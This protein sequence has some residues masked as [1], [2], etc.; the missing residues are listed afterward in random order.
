M[1]LVRDK[2]SWDN[3]KNKF[4]GVSSYFC[5]NTYVAEVI[6]MVMIDNQP[7]I[8]NIWC[9]VDCGIVINKNSAKNMIEGTTYYEKKID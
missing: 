1:N 7:K 2:S 9:A 5:H 8:K 6:E 4:K 3:D